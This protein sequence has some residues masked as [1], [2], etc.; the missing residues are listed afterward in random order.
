MTH[1]VIKAWYD[2]LAQRYPEVAQIKEDDYQMY[3]E[4]EI[5]HVKQ[6]RKETQKK[7]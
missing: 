2:Y 6:I 4:E 7:N 5:E 1:K 3:N